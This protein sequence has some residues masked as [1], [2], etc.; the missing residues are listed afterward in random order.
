MGT[1]DN[2]LKFAVYCF[3]YDLPKRLRR[4]EQFAKHPQATTQRRQRFSELEKADKMSRLHS[5]KTLPSKSN[6]QNSACLNKSSKIVRALL[7]VPTSAAPSLDT[8]KEQAPAGDESINTL[9]GL[10]RPSCSSRNGQRRSI[11]AAL[12]E[13]AA[14]EEERRQQQ[15]ERERQRREEEEK[16]TRGA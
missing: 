8:Y 15:E 9:T 5:T 11:E 14:L 16:V 1:P 4:R 6:G 13:Q 10:Q 3:F 12:Q 7:S 2:T